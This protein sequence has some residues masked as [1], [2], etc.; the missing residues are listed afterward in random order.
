MPKYPGLWFKDGDII[1][2]PG[3]PDADCL[4]FL[5]HKKILS[6][7]SPQFAAMFHHPSEA[8]SGIRFFQVNDRVEDLAVLLRCLYYPNDLPFKRDKPTI[9]LDRLLRICKKYR[10]SDLAASVIAQLKFEW[11]TSLALWEVH[12]TRVRKLGIAHA[13]APDGLIDGQYLDDRFPEPASIIRLAR[14]FNIPELL[15]AAFYALSLISPSAAYDTYHTPAT[16]ALP[17]HAAKLARLAR[18]ARWGLLMPPDLL[19]LAKGRD[20][21]RSRKALTQILEKPTRSAACRAGCDTLLAALRDLAEETHDILG[22]LTYLRLYITDPV[23]PPKLCAVCAKGLCDEI[24]ALR[25]RI[26]VNF[27]HWAGLDV[28]CTA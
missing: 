12:E 2:S 15:P 13:A 17:H 5:V 6:R 10:I 16:R 9:N 14:E 1:L 25:L 27:P 20:F 22:A 8:I 19:C 28:K 21:L 3:T 24:A 18:S 7:H 26:W 23:N 11:P 4:R